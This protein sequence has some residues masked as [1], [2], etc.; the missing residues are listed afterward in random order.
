VGFVRTILDINM[1]RSHLKY[2][3]LQKKEKR[4]AGILQESYAWSNK[5]I[6]VLLHFVELGSYTCRIR[7]FD[8]DGFT[9][10]ES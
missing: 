1:I 7:P 10:T 3:F 9:L 8:I 5:H 2:H 4:N 6:Y